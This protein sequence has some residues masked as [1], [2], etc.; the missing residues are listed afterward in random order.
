MSKQY[1]VENSDET[2]MRTQYMSF[3]EIDLFFDSAISPKT[4]VFI[5]RMEK[6]EQTILEF[7]DGSTSKLTKIKVGWPVW[8]VA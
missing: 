8:S 6:D 5:R 1:K 7:V 4:L 3:D 2:G